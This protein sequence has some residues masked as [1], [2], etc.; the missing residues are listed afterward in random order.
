MNSNTA[1]EALTALAHERRLAIFQTLMEVGPNGLAAGEIAAALEVPPSTLS[2]HLAQLE[3]AGLL[4]SWRR[5]RNILYAVE[6][7]GMRRLV[8]FLIEDCCHGHPELCGLGTQGG[9]APT[10]ET[11]KAPSPRKPKQPA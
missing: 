1:V 7:D 10:T 9:C 11:A 6:V 4:R 8:S 5:S 3:R 2:S